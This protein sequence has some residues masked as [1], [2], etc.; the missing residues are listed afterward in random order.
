VTNFCIIECRIFV[1]VIYLNGV[2][3]LHA[4]SCMAVSTIDMAK[5]KQLS[6]KEKRKIV[7]LINEK[8]VSRSKVAQAMGRSRGTIYYFL[9]KLEKTEKTERKTVLAKEDRKAIVALVRKKPSLSLIRI[10]KKLALKVS[11]PTIT[12][13]LH[14]RGYRCETQ[15]VANWVRVDT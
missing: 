10:Q 15:G 1:I 2:S 6:N 8:G 4:E 11:L 12:R 9:R 14:K 13:C 3:L 5:C 7:R